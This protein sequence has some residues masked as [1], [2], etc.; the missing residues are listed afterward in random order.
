MASASKG[1]V[2]VA[3]DGS[4]HSHRAID[5]VAGLFPGRRVIVLSV[6][7]SAAA[8]APAHALTTTAGVEAY[9]RVDK[10]AE[11][12]ADSIAAE[13]AEHLRKAGCDATAVTLGSHGGTAQVVLDHAERSG[14]A[15]IAL[16]SRGRSQVKSLL[17]GSVSNGVVQN[18]TRPVLVVRDDG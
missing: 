1:P 13:G 10:A 18:A 3:H 2:L 6:W 15:V 12:V 14:A 16:G 4:E 5:A 8:F 7:E 11:E 9:A 17:L